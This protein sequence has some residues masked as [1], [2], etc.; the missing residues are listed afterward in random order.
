MYSEYI[1][2]CMCF[3]SIFCLIFNRTEK[4]EGVFLQKWKIKEDSTPPLPLPVG[5]VD[6]IAFYVV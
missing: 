6:I 5:V 2:V 3:Y 1:Y 4:G